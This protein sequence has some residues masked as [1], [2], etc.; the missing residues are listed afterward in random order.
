MHGNNKHFSYFFHASSKWSRFFH[1]D[2][3]LLG[4][5]DVIDW[6]IVTRLEQNVGELGKVEA[7]YVTRRRPNKELMTLTSQGER[8]HRP[9]D[10]LL[11]AAICG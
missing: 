1:C 7:I 6:R 4:E 5:G 9:L 3:D 2:V 10:L 11:L 8:Q